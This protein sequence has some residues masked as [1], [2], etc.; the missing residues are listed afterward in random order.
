M[1]GKN[2][3]TAQIAHAWDVDAKHG[4]AMPTLTVRAY[5]DSGGDRR[6]FLRIGEE[7]I[8]LECERKDG[9]LKLCV[10]YRAGSKDTP[11]QQIL[12]IPLET[13]YA[14]LEAQ[15]KQ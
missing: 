13:V 15:A 3:M 6:V 5:D 9:A 12:E 14:N 1:N 2:E 10:R 7:V 4:V 11:P 8:M